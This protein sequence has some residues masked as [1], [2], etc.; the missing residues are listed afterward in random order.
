MVDKSK[1]RKNKSSNSEASSTTDATANV[2]NRVSLVF[3]PTSKC[4]II[5]TKQ[6]PDI[7]VYSVVDKS[8]KKKNRSSA[9]TDDD[10]AAN[11]SY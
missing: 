4:I 10:P 3:L 1:K 9:T 11:V 5:Y 7:P 8:K 2:S 6:A